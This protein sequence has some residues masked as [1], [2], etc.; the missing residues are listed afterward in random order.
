MPRGNYYKTSNLLKISTP[1][2]IYKKNEPT[3][4]QYNEES[5]KNEPTIQKDNE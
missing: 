5:K 4:Q 3:I 1:P 2:Q